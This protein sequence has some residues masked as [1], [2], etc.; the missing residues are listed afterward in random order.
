MPYSSML[1][2]PSLKTFKKALPEKSIIN[3]YI[4]SLPEEEKITATNNIGAHLSQRRS[5]YVM[6]RG[7][8]I[9]D[10]AI[11]LT[12]R[13]MNQGER[14]ALENIKTDPAYIPVFKSGGFYVFK[15]ISR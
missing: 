3:E 15:R 5:I 6:P 11:F 9:S 1:S 2:I 13:S 4:A 7:L 10:R 8:D 14:A 12:T